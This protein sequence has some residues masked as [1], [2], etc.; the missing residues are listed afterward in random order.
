MDG[1][2]KGRELEP[3]GIWVCPK[4]GSRIEVLM[5]MTC[6]PACHNHIGGKHIIME[7]VTKRS[8]KEK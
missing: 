6:P 3:A 1:A 2:P 4:C 5:A 7:R 8:K